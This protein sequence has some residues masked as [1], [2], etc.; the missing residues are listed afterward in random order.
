M[1][2]CRKC[3]KKLGFLSKKHNY[4]DDD[5][6]RFKYCQD[7][8]REAEEIERKRIEKEQSRM[9]KKVLPMIRNFIGTLDGDKQVQ[10]YDIYSNE[11]PFS[12]L[13][14]ESLDELRNYLHKEIKT[15]RKAA[16]MGW[17]DYLGTGY[18]PADHIEEFEVCLSLLDDMEKV[19][20]IIEKKADFAVTFPLLVT[21]AGEVFDEANQHQAKTEKEDF[22]NR[23]TAGVDDEET[24]SDCGKTVKSASKFCKYCGVER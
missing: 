13:G 1:A 11:N 20:H 23:I 21:W 14:D 3:G 9:K 10:L 5:G 4:E 2:D 17:V 12:M 8:H 7:C 18:N 15:G 19:K 16:T 22:E 6:N 24:C